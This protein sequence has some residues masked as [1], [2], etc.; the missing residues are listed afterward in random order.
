MSAEER[1]AYA[2][3]SETDQRLQREANQAGAKPTRPAEATLARMRTELA[4]LQAQLDDLPKDEYGLPPADAA[5][6]TEAVEL[7]LKSDDWP[8]VSHEPNTFT[9]LAWGR[10]VVAGLKA[11]SEFMKHSHGLVPVGYRSGVDRSAQMYQVLLPE[12][13]D[14][15]ASGPHRLIVNLHGASAIE[16]PVTW[17]A[18]TPNRAKDLNIGAITI[19]PFGRGNNMYAWTAETD[20]W[21][22]IE[23]VKRRYAIDEN[24]VVLSGFSMGGGGTVALGLTHPGPFA[25]ISPLAP[26]IRSVST[27]PAASDLPIGPKRWAPLTNEEI[28]QRVDRVYAVLA[29]AEN[30]C[31]LPVMLGCGGDDRLLR[32][33]ESLSQ[34]FNATGV[35]YS[36]YVM[37]GVG[38]AGDTV[39]AQPQYRQFLLTHRRDPTP[40]EVTFA[41]A[42]LKSA[43]RAWITIE[44]LTVHYTK[45]KIH[46]VADPAKGTLIVTTDGIERF[47][48]TPPESLVKPDNTTIS[49]D[50]EKVAG[51]TLS[52][53]RV[54]GKWREARGSVPALSKRPG[55]QGPVADAFT[56]PFLCVRPTCTPW[57][58]TVSAHALAMIEELRAY[59]RTQQ[60]G[61]L[62]MKDD[63][64]VTA[65]DRASFDLILFGDP[66]SNRLMAE[67][68]LAK[69]PWA[70]PL[71]WE[72]DSIVLG[73]KRFAADSH[74][75]VMIYP[76]PLQAG[77]YVVLNGVPL[78]HGLRRYRGD[79]ATEGSPWRL[80][81]VTLGDF[82]IM[83]V[84]RIEDG[85]HIAK[86]I[87][88]GFFN[89]KWQ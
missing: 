32:V 45:A 5:I 68:L 12:G 85:A 76:S 50:G 19:R 29:L 3:Q 79:S 82:A 46:A 54:D 80:L 48:L 49:V 38:H 71:R 86:S 65:A 42:S 56:R 21:D 41:T 16:R 43:S 37:A 36:A 78:D 22:A 52:F 18:T 55:L 66:G 81:P 1:A 70:L 31:G 62:P 17:I 83:Q 35:K 57:N 77:R 13:F 84:S 11:D 4:E 25:A 88:A 34:A 20:V 51:T 7:Q 9:C 33:Q 72:K 47:A 64:A 61:E 39:C 14:P 6:Y 26:A 74:L 44:G 23:D 75:P 8:G 53:E 28:N 2:R 58:E 63:I 40:R 10:A 89:E 69:S 67:V 24:Q 15:A 87:Y 27:M 60:F 30:G 73:S 59:W